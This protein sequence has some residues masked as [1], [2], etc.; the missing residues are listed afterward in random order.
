[1]QKYDTMYTNSRDE[2]EAKQRLVQF[3]TPLK[4]SLSSATENGFNIVNDK[5]YY[6]NNNERAFYSRKLY[7]NSFVAKLQNIEKARI[8]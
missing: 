4:Q 2:T 6:K 1:M 3:K 8:F 5:D 7:Y